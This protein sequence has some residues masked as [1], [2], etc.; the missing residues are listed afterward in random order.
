MK[1]GRR[2][3]RD[4]A[5]FL[6]I[7]ALTRSLESAFVKHGVPFQIVK[8]LAF[9]DRKENRDVLAYLRLLVNPQDTRQLPAGGERAG[10]RASARCRSTGCVTYAAER[11]DR[12]CSRPPG[13]SRKIPDIKGK[14]ATGLRDFHR[15]M[16]ELRAQARPAAARAD[17]PR[18]RQ[19]RLPARCSRESSDE[20]DADRLANI[21]ELITAAKQFHDEDTEPHHRRLPRTDHPGVATW[22]AGTRQP[23]TCR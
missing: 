17:P 19:V 8:G 10:P 20:E 11:R 13:R 15:L 1:A 22:T 21:E 6:R 4:H 12:R 7:N 2:R 5:I 18:A 14:A 9:F 3:Y 23:T 16:T